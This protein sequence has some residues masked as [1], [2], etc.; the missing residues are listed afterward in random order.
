MTMCSEVKLKESCV[1]R[2]PACR[3]TSL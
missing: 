3:N 2:E 1:Q